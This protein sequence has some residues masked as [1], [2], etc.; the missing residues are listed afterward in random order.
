MSS[1]LRRRPF[2]GGVAVLAALCLG[3]S[4]S[5]ANADTLDGETF[6]H[7][8]HSEA[9]AWSGDCNPTGPS[10]FQFWVFGDASGPHPGSFEESGTVTLAS[11][12]GPVTAF[13][14][15]WSIYESESTITGTRTLGESF[16]ASCSA[17]DGYGSHTFSIDIDA[18]YEVLDPFA[19]LGPSTVKLGAGTLDYGGFEARFG[20]EHTPPP[21]TQNEPLSKADCRNG[22]YRDYGFK[23]QGACIKFVV[24]AAKDDRP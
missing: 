15:S 20:S 21:P 7:A 10:T 5:A 17:P 4:A 18:P 24:K 13:E 14:S 23:N 8:N 1:I 6:T 2:A 22:G 12:T 19:E 3:A 16:A 9:I 11:P